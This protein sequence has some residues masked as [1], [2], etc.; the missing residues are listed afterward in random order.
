MRKVIAILEWGIIIVMYVRWVDVQSFFR[1]N[2]QQPLAAKANVVR[3]V[4][5]AIDRRLGQV[6]GRPGA[7]L[8]VRRLS[9]PQPREF[10][11]LE[12]AGILKPRH[13]AASVQPA[14]NDNRLAVRPVD[15]P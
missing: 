3:S 7:V 10:K 6:L 15:S 9:V 12:D 5:L 8:D 2:V 13:Q 4:P 11:T 14:A 1:T